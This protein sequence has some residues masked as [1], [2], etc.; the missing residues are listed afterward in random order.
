MDVG[1]P[2]ARVNVERIAGFLHSTTTE[3]SS[4]R[5][6]RRRRSRPRCH[7]RARDARGCSA[8]AH[9]TCASARVSPRSGLLPPPRDGR[10]RCVGAGRRHHG[11]L[12]AA[13]VAEL[14]RVSRRR[15]VRRLARSVVARERRGAHVDGG[16]R[17]GGFRRR[18]A[19]WRGDGVQVPRGLEARDGLGGGREP[20]HPRVRLGRR[21]VRRHGHVRRRRRRQ[22]RGGGGSVGCGGGGGRGGGGDAGRPRRRPVFAPEIRALPRRRRRRSRPPPPPSPPS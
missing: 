12:R 7:S 16:G 4:G 19:V 1:A 3:S 10:W 15:R 13:R 14:W 17:L 18:R 22:I 5:S 8:R 2:R 21:R 6:V 9:G 11:H 20:R